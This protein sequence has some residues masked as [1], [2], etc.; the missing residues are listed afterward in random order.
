M[1]YYRTNLYF[2][3]NLIGVSNTI[4]EQN[5]SP[6]FNARQDFPIGPVVLILTNVFERSELLR[7]KVIHADWWKKLFVQVQSAK[8]QE[9]ILQKPK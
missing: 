3:N 5:A 8:I 2:V 9:L 6:S 1:N 4:I 7:I